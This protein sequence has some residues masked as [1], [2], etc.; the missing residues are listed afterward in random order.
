M[1]LIVRDDATN[2]GRALL[3]AKELV[4]EQKVDLLYPG[5]I[6]GTTMAALP[7]TTAQKVVTISN[8][9]SPQIGDVAKFPYSFQLADLVTKRIPPLAAAIKRLE[10]ERRSEFWL[11]PTHRRSL[12]AMVSPTS[13]PVF[14]ACRSSATSSIRVTPRTSRR[15]FKA[16]ARRARTSSLSALWRARACAS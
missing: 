3:A 16:F 13:F 11:A 9:A 6:S 8:G 12:L 7:F 14:M 15:S 5:I 4:S 1:Q 2:P 10:E